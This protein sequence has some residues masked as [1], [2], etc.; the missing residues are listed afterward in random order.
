[1]SGTSVVTVTPIPTTPNVTPAGPLVVCE[2]SSSVVLTSDAASG[3]QWYKDGSPIGGATA[4]TLNITTVP[5]NSGSYTVISTVSGCASAVSNAASVTIDALPLNSPGVSPI[6]T[7]ICSGSSVTVTIVGTE[8][9]INY[10]LFDGSTPVSA[11]VAGTGGSINLI[12]SALTASTTLTVEAMNAITG[13]SIILPGTTAVTVSASI[14]TP[15]ISPVS[16]VIAC[17]GDPTIVLTSSAIS[18]NQWY[19]DG[20]PMPGEVNQTLNIS[21]GVVNSGSYTVYEIQ[22]GCTSAA[23]LPVTVTI[24]SIASPPV[25]SNP[26]PICV[27]QTIPTL[28]ASGSNLN[29]YSDAALTMLVGT[30]SPFTPSASEVDNMTAGSYPL[31]VT[32]T[33]G[34]ESAATIVTVVVNPVVAANA[35]V[36]TNLCDGQNIILGEVQRQ[37]VV[38][39]HIR[40][41]GPACH[42]VSQVHNQI[43]L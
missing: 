29:W 6:N 9:G 25:A 12:S 43:R 2:G 20:V 39:E 19:K 34:C 37:R 23:S 17:V 31:Y 33:I 16:P 32:Q 42:R 24:N 8:S 21:T 22:S 28:T 18:G 3:N 10:R 11:F 5:G 27:G 4:T 35:G 14:P 15:V 7:T 41:A 40:I 1:M 36:N 13:C 30:G 26:N 38:A